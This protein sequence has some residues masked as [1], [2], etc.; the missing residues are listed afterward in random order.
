MEFYPFVAVRVCTF[1]GRIWWSQTHAQRQRRT[2]PR[3]G[4]VV[5]TVAGQRGVQRNVGR[6]TVL[7]IFEQLVVPSFVLRYPQRV[8][9][10]EVVIGPAQS[11]SWLIE[12]VLLLM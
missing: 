4:R 2:A 1:D 3:V 12:A 9:K 5:N 7:E 10:C 11:A 6:L 8:A